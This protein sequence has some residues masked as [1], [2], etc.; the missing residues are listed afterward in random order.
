M[1]HLIWA[2]A[3]TSRWRWP[4]AVP[5]ARTS[6]GGACLARQDETPPRA[7]TLNLI[8]GTGQ[9]V[10]VQD[11]TVGLFSASGAQVVFG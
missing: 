4:G 6:A 2:A 9:P 10:S 5:A 11:A 7:Y 3:W 1:K 8:N